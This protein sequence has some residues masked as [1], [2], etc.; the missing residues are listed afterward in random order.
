V[1]QLR[2]LFVQR[3]SWLNCTPNERTFGDGFLFS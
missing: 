2:E 1:A 3:G